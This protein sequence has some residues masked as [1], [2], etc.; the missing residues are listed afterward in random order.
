MHDSTLFYRSIYAALFIGASSMLYSCNDDIRPGDKNDSSDRVCFRLT[1]ASWGN[2]AD[3]RSTS[4]VSREIGRAVL[5]STESSDTLCLTAIETDGINLGSSTR[6]SQ[7]SSK[8]DLSSFGC[9]AYVGTTP[10]KYTQFYINNDE[11]TKNGEIYQSENIQ[12]WPGSALNFKFYCYAP[13]NASGL[14][15]PESPESTILQYEVPASVAD[16]KDLML[17]PTEEYPGNRN[18]QVPLTFTHLLSAVKVISGETMQAG[19]V[20][21]V[22]FTGLHGQATI[23]M[24]AVDNEGWDYLGGIEGRKSFSSSDQI[25]I[26]ENESKKNLISTN[27][28]DAFMFLP[29]TLSDTENS[30]IIEFNDGEK[31]RTLTAPLTGLWEM[32]KTYTY[33]ISITPEYE[34]SFSQVPD[35]QDAHY[36]SCMTTIHVNNIPQ[37]KNWILTA[38]ASDGA[39]VTVQLE[40]QVNEYAKE[41][42]WVDKIMNNGVLSTESARG[43]NSIV[44]NENGEIEVR[45]FIP[46]N[47]G[48]SNRTITLSLGIEGSTSSRAIQSIEQYCPDW[49]SDN[50]GWEQ[51]DDNQSS[52]W[53]FDSN[54]VQ[55]YVFNHFSD[56]GFI[57]NISKA[58][59]GNVSTLINNLISDN[60][61]SSYVT[62]GE[63]EHGVGWFAS[64]Y[65]YVVIN[66]STLSNLG[67]NANSQT[68]GIL[69]TQQL[70]TMAGPVYNNFFENALT[71]LKKAWS[72]NPLM[73]KRENSNVTFPS[74]VPESIEDADFSNGFL[75]IILKKNRGYINKIT[76]GTGDN[77]VTT[78]V[79]AYDVNDL[80]W[81]L[82]AYGQF[83][84][85][86]SFGDNTLDSSLYWSSTGVS[87]STDSYLGNGAQDSRKTSHKVVV[88]RNKQ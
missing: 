74:N 24:D 19:T 65:N 18:E 32:G 9:F 38:S 20:K 21:S 82:P 7:I 88:C 28:S 1:E 54:R 13:F 50:T 44:S 49:K 53:G 11:Y 51:I 67:S 39:D 85:V 61:A 3:T 22:S 34:L 30:I 52:P 40:T 72:G 63:Y 66:Y 31:D 2:A 15:L 42:Y 62:I 59:L 43:T 10:G 87:N 76:Q 27:E 25:T 78:T 35:K 36:V 16:Q 71:G 4:P 12:Y 37:G 33:I 86:T 46:E 55:V 80:V 69:N 58:L 84:G 60:N 75:P 26:A 48:T 41:G 14:G 64:T 6:G 68:N 17:A 57:D 45:V 29:Q 73:I 81:Y 47:N 23:N 5:R 70:Y 79:L 8:D 83:N 56:V 77:Q